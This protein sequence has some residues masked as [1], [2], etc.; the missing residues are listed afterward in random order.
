[1]RISSS[2]QR[3]YLVVASQGQILII[4]LCKYQEFNVVFLKKRCSQN[5][6]LLQL[7]RHHCHHV[8]KGSVSLSRVVAAAKHYLSFFCQCIEKPHGDRIHVLEPACCGLRNGLFI[9]YT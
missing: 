1:M 8:V 7:T 9:L 3:I 6:S 4:I 2:A 5:L